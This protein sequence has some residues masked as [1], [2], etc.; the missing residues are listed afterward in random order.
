MI[1]N[2]RRLQALVRLELVEHVLGIHGRWLVV[3]QLRQVSEHRLEKTVSNSGPFVIKDHQ[4]TNYIGLVPA[5]KSY[6]VQILSFPP[7]SL[8]DH[9]LDSFRMPIPRVRRDP[10]GLS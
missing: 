3:G 6:D 2:T 8:T 5:L 1:S 7:M 9:L 10:F 4:H